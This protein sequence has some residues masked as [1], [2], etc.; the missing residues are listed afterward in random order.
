MPK[1]GRPRKFNRDEAI[2]NAML[3]FWEQ[4]FES[5]SLSQ[6]REA[7]GNISASSF[8]TTFK[9]KETL[10]EEVIK[11]YMDTFGQVTFCLKDSS[12]EPKH[13]I[14][15][16][17]RQSAKMQTDGAHPLGCLL[18]LSAT[19]CSVE[20]AHIRDMLSKQRKL[21][22]GWLTACIQNAVEKGQLK[23]TTDVTMLTTVFQS[24]LFG[25]STQVMDGV[26]FDTIN[27]AITQIMKVWD[28]LATD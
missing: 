6:L 12:L 4:G 9:S 17:L 16:A 3:L 23:E 25:I 5:T 15:Q 24:F 20:N 28:F 1:P 21:T 8:Y 13:A 14:E 22:R 10:F 19:T 26:K 18:V 7:M 2:F 11:M 27:D